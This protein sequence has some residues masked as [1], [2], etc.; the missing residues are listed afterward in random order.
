MMLVSISMQVFFVCNCQIRYGSL[1][2]QHGA[3]WDFTSY[4]CMLSV[5]LYPRLSEYKLCCDVKSGVCQG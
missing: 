4:I 5:L 1:F 2:L 3:F